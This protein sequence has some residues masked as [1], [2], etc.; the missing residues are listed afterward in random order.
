MKWLPTIES[1]CRPRN[2]GPSR[3]PKQPKVER[4]REREGLGAAMAM[5]PPP[6]CLQHE[7]LSPAVCSWRAKT[8]ERER[9]RARKVT[10]FVLIMIKLIYYINSKNKTIPSEY[11]S[12]RDFL[13]SST[14]ALGCASRSLKTLSMTESSVA[15]VSD[16]QKAVQSLTVNPAAMTSLPLLTVPAT[17]GT[18]RSVESSSRSSIEAAPVGDHAVAANE[19]VPG[20]GLPEDFHSRTS[21]M[22]SSVSW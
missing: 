3:L 6:A 14:M 8:S 5:S 18:W 22:S 13:I 16:P 7:E 9:E 20:D 17:S 12:M 2:F 19:D 10:G 15:V 11:V 1:S 21:A 4:E